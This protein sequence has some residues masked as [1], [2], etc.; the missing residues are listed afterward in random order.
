MRPEKRKPRKTATA[1]AARIASIRC[2][3]YTRKSTEE[4]L[5]QAFNTLDAQREAGGGV[6]QQPAAGRLGGVA[7]E[8][9]R[10]RLHRRQ[11][12]PARR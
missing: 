12:G 10:R 5:D 11:H 2:A 9:R 4:G 7:A 6:H 3:I 8:V 1:S